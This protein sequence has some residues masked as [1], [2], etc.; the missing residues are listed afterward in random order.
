MMGTEGSWSACFMTPS[1]GI[2]EDKRFY[3]HAAVFVT[4]RKLVQLLCGIY[5]LWGKGLYFMSV[6]HHV[7]SMLLVEFSGSHQCYSV[8]A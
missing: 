7:A 2:Y 4:I 1:F 8:I 6:H 3:I 5:L